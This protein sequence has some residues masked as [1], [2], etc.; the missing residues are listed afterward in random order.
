[1]GKGRDLYARRKDGSEFPVEIGLN[2]IE[3]NEGTLILSAIVD[4]SKRKQ[5]EQRIQAALEEKTSS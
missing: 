1:M 5:K 4:I 3:T 2:P